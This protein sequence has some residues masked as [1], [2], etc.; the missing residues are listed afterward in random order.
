MPFKIKKLTCEMPFKK[1]KKSFQCQICLN[2]SDLYCHCH[3]KNAV[4][5]QLSSIKYL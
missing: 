1:E 3:H 2:D 5:L 4:V